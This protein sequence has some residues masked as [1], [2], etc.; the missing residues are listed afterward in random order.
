MYLDSLET[1]LSVKAFALWCVGR[2]FSINWL[3]QYIFSVQSFQSFRTC[4]IQFIWCNSLNFVVKEI[5]SQ[6]IYLTQ[7]FTTSIYFNNKILAASVIS[8]RPRMPSDDQIMFQPHFSATQRSYLKSLPTS[9]RAWIHLFQG[10]WLIWLLLFSN[11]Y[12][13]NNSYITIKGALGSFLTSMEA[14]GGKPS[15]VSGW[16]R[17][18]E[19][20]LI[21]INLQLMTDSD[22]GNQ[23]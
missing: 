1:R 10:V 7:S 23:R 8:P 18:F 19:R 14:R 13:L 3:T 21:I 22:C 2:L 17:M 6:R 5:E 9:Q 4:L 15:Q 16:T 12:F 20:I 11:I